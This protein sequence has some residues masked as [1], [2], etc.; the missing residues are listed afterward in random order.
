M[1]DR[2][3]DR[4]FKFGF[5]RNPWDWQVSLYHF[6]RQRASHPQ[7]DLVLAMGGFP[8]FLKWRVESFSPENLQNTF[9][10]DAEGRL[11]V[12]FIGRFE[13][14]REDFLHLMEHLGKSVN[15]K[16]TRRRVS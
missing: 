7:H 14:L 10:A 1:D 16:K 5:V 9:L 13:T 12:D 6:I 3:F 2:L 4:F 8:E 11:L 15:A